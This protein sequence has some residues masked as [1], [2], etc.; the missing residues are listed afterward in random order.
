[1]KFIGVIRF[2]D[3][4]L[5]TARDLVRA[6]NLGYVGDLDGHDVTIARVKEILTETTDTEYALLWAN[7]MS[8]KD[9]LALMRK[10]VGHE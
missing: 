10:E 2:N 8:F 1:M 3:V 7:G 6:V 9:I 5:S 4:D